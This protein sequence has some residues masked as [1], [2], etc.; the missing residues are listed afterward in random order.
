MQWVHMGVASRS[1]ANA[2][3]FFVTVL[4][5]TKSGPKTLAVPVSKG[6][7]GVA[8]DL[9]MI[10]YD[11]DGIQFEVFIDPNR[12]DSNDPIV[13]ACLA[14]E[15]RDAFVAH[16]EAHDIEVRRVPKGERTLIFIRDYDGNLYEIKEAL[17]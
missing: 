4:G 15:D 11:G 16:C 7:F 9:P 6:C 10:Y 3:R 2:D 5:L 12:K 13:H 8:A 1:E 17:Q 14:V